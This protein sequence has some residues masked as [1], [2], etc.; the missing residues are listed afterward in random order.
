MQNAK[1]TRWILTFSIAILLLAIGLLWVLRAGRPETGGDG[2]RPS[3]EREDNGP[4]RL[5]LPKTSPVGPRAPE[6][7]KAQPAPPVS[8]A[9]SPAVEATPFAPQAQDPVAGQAKKA[10]ATFK[11]RRVE[12]IP[13]MSTNPPPPTGFS[14]QTEALINMIVNTP[15]GSPP[16]PLLRVSPR[17]DLA[18]IFETDILVY[19]EDDE[20]T[21][22]AKIN[23]AKAKEYLKEYLEQG[24]TPDGFLT[25]YHDQLRAAHQEWM[26]ARKQALDLIKAGDAEG[27][28]LYA[29]EQNKDFAKRGIKPIVIPGL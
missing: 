21:V 28:L 24:G 3:V 12:V 20:Q 15:L 2:P 7:E 19:D 17:E 23:V 26:L 9:V 13:G 16:P 22:A 18:K 14:S 1:N 11:K 5:A 27:A 8:P 4:P 25:Y 6:A 10:P 29:E